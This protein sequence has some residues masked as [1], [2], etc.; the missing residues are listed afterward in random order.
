MV[1]PYC[2]FGDKNGPL[3]VFL[4]AGGVSGWMWEEQV[5]YFQKGF[6]CVVPDLPEHG[7]NP[8][9][10]PFTIRGCAEEVRELVEAT[11]N[12]QP[13]ILVGFS[14]GAQVVV[15]VLS[16]YPDLADYAMINSALVRP[17]ASLLRLLTPVVQMSH[18]LVKKEWF[19]K[20]QAKMLDI[21]EE[22]FPKY[23]ADS[24][25]MSE[26]ALLRITRENM[27]FSL[28]AGFRHARA[29]ILVTVGDKERKMMKESAR[30]IVSANPNAVG[31]RIPGSGHG[32]SL[33]KPKYFNHLL[34]GWLHKGA[35]PSGA[36]LIAPLRPHEKS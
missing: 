31:L 23:F 4:H 22:D 18:P 14:L 21:P 11:A 6:H 3:L 35:I 24:S 26:E 33:A 9:S 2:E 20:L 25:Q 34:Q 29:K 1:L 5:R 13:V 7:V 17:D 12:G 8:G 28:P 36:K 30:D 15:Q 27:Q 16:L 19:A 32:V 10:Q